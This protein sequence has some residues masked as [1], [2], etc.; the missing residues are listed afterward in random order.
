MCIIFNEI[1]LEAGQKQ[2][3]GQCLVGHDACFVRRRRS[4]LSG[5]L[6]AFCLRRET[7]LK[8]RQCLIETADM[9]QEP[10]KLGSFDGDIVC[11]PPNNHL[12]KFEGTLTWKGKRYATWKVI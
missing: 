10:Q 3:L 1:L 9:G 4:Y 7:N 5:I 11:E 8:C 6:Y 2:E 12:N